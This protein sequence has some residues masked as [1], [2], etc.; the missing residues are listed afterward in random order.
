ML[1]VTRIHQV[2]QDLQKRDANN[3]LAKRLLNHDVTVHV[4]EQPF[5]D[6]QS[7]LYA[8]S[9]ISVNERVA[10]RHAQ[11]RRIRRKLKYSRMH[12]KSEREMHY[13]IAKQATRN[14]KKSPCGVSINWQWSNQETEVVVGARGIRQGKK[15]KSD[16]DYKNHDVSALSCFSNSVCTGQ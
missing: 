11:K 4:V 6:G 9:G 16:Q 5:S 7:Y 12:R 14:T 1:Y 3:E 13:G 15:P 8:A 10:R 2:I